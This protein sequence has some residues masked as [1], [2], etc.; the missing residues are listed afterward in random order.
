MDKLYTIGE[1][2]ACMGDPGAIIDACS[3]IYTYN[4]I[5]DDLHMQFDIIIL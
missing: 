2:H 5:T 1:M 3:Y 4:Y